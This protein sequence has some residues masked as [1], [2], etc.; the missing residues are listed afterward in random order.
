MHFSS[1]AVSYSG[2]KAYREAIMAPEFR[3]LQLTRLQLSSAI[4]AV[5]EFIKLVQKEAAENPQGGEHE[6]I[7]VAESV[8]RELIRARN[9]SA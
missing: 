6:D 8:L 2:R 9:A 3:N 7:L 4:V 5:Q 1:A